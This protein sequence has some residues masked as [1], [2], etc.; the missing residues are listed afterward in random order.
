MNH[1]NPEAAIDRCSEKKVLWNFFKKE[2]KLK[3]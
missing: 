2:Q 1:K 3:T